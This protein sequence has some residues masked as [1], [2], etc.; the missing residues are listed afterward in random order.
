[1]A[2]RKGRTKQLLENAIDCALLAVEIYNKPRAQFRVENYITNMIMAWTKLLHAHL[3]NSI[4]DKYF[5]KKK[6]ARVY[7]MI[8]GERKAWEL[9]TCLVNVELEKSVKAN[10]LFFIKLRN[11]IEHRYI[12]KEEVGII[13]FGECQSL[14]NNFEDFVVECFGEEYALNECLAFALQFSK[15]RTNGQ[16]IASKTLLSKEVI[17][18]REY[19]EKYRNSLDDETF[20]SQSYSIKLISVPK[21]SNTHRND[22]AV[23]FVNWKELSLEEREYYEKLV[24]ITKE[25]NIFVESINSGK[26]KPSAVLNRVEELCGTKISHYD[27]KC[28]F[29]IFSIR[30]SKLDKETDPFN[31]NTTFCHYDEAHDDYL[32]QQD[33]CNFISNGI[34]NNTL[35]KEQWTKLYKGEKKIDIKQFRNENAI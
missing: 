10:L 5:Y 16:L 4:G 11:K 1:M 7:E 29:T 32:Y 27:H 33:W 24:A 28:L 18:I 21:I 3:H 23:E 30:P 17:E 14:L 34:R 15:L 22:L 12:D 6:G 26:L 2:L 9:K 35:N 31:T 13:I 8:D 20:N 19:I 25:K